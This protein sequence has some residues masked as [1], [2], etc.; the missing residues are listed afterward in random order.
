[1]HSILLTVDSPPPTMDCTQVR[2]Y[3]PLYTEY[4]YP[5]NR[6]TCVWTSH[7][8]THTLPVQYTVHGYQSPLYRQ[9]LYTLA[10]FAY[11]VRCRWY[12][13]SQATGQR[14]YS[15]P[16]YTPTRYTLW[17]TIWRLTAPLTG[18]KRIYRPSSRILAPVHRIPTSGQ[19]EHIHLL[20]P[21]PYAPHAPSVHRRP[22]SRAPS[23][24]K[25]DPN[26]CLTRMA[27]ALEP[28]LGSTSLDLHSTRLVKTQPTAPT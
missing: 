9:K 26:R 15:L 10:T 5:D 24:A 7:V 19:P 28:S 8:Y 11:I 17:Y 14:T 25:T 16:V 18:Q 4:W 12:S 3:R 13:H 21:H 23:P 20:C 2:V 6:T 22:V 27:L 1:M